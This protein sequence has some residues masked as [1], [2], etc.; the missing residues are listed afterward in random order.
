VK[1]VY[2]FT[3]YISVRFHSGLE[4]KP[5]LAFEKNKTQGYVWNYTCKYI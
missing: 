2:I 3:I 1:W 4:L 5:A